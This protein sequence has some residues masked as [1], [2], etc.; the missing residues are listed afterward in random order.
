MVYDKKWQ[1]LYEGKIKEARYEPDRDKVE[2][3]ALV[4]SIDAWARQAPK[5]TQELRGAFESGR[6]VEKADKAKLIRLEKAFKKLVADL[7]KII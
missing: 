7:Y 3:I 5:A 6:P 2:V 4:E 1:K